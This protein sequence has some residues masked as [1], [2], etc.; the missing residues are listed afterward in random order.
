MLQGSQLLSAREKCF[1]FSNPPAEST[2]LRCSISRFFLVRASVVG[3]ARLV[4]Q[5]LRGDHKVEQ[6]DLDAD[7]REVVRVPELGR[8]VEAEVL[9]VLYRGVPEA[10]AVAPA[11][12]ED[13][14]EQE[15]LEGRV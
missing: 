8:D 7:L 14:L 3:F 4:L 5:S 12:L 9:A 11:L 6:G 13:L 15:R 10:D 1:I 2:S